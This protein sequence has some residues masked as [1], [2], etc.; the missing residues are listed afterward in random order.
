M[1]AE[2]AAPD[3]VQ[4]VRQT[5]AE[6]G[7]IRIEWDAVI[8][9]DI[10]YKV[11][12][13]ASRNFSGGIQDN[14]S[15]SGKS[16]TTNTSC[17]FTGL[18]PG[19]AYYVRVT[20]FHNSNYPNY[21]HTY[22][23]SS[24][25][26]QVVTKPNNKVTN[27]RQT[28]AAVD[29][30]T[31]TWNKAAG[32]NAYRIE[33]WKEG[34]GGR[35]SAKKVVEVG[36]VNSYKAK[37]LTKNEEYQFW[38]YPINKSEKGY[39]AVGEY[40]WEYIS[41]VPTLPTKI[42]GLDCEFWSE[43]SNYLEL[44]YDKRASEDGIQYEIYEEKGKKPIIKGTWKTCSLDPYFSYKKLKGYQFRKL[45]VRSY[46]DIGG[47]RKYGEWSDW[48]YF[49]RQPKVKAKKASGG[50]KLSWSKIKGAKDY[51]VYASTKEKSGYKK[52]KTTKNTS[53][54]LTKCGN[55]KLKNNKTY[56]YYVVANKKVG[57]KTYKSDE[58]CVW[59]SLYKK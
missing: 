25:V 38:I 52:F 57:K 20:A 18:T 29:S 16:G 17:S 11:E 1:K 10:E 43:V 5:D 22:G 37:K 31:V 34:S 35:E 41:R 12:L 26:L 36:N 32:A 46:I 54:V 27:F 30:I 9:N 39:K 56:Y 4:G 33:W 47:K 2:A 6:T 48:E 59:Y 7:S 44:S 14:L 53:I 23:A 50:I 21:I 3:K 51:T 49:A 58:I 24:D 13:C 28:K 45:R 8:G 15:Y 55:S 40:K 19:K 42:T